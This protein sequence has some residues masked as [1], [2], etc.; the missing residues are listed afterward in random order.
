[1]M[2]LI[3]A[4]MSFP[5]IPGGGE[6]SPE[7]VWLMP[8][9]PVFFPSVTRAQWEAVSSETGY[10]EPQSQDSRQIRLLICTLNKVNSIH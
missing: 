2:T 8:E 10:V 6:G 9:T 3:S 5:S 7:R 1:M 4:Q